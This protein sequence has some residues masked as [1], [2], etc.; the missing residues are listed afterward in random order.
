MSKNNQKYFVYCVL[1]FTDKSLFVVE[2]KYVS[3]CYYRFLYDF[4][5][6]ECCYL[7][8]KYTVVVQAYYLLLNLQRSSVL[9]IYSTHLALKKC[10]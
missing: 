9:T 2:C 4:C 10:Y 6:I 1:S 5:Y 7:S 8:R 3:Q